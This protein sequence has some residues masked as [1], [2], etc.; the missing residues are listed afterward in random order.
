LELAAA[1]VAQAVEEVEELHLTGLLAGQVAA[2]V[3]QVAFPQ[4]VTLVLAAEGAEA[5][6]EEGLRAALL[7][8]GVAPFPVSGPIA[9]C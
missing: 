6:E 4:S 1:E 8:V 7:V 2:V 9:D 5:V 3:E